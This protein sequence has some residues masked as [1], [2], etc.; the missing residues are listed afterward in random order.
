MSACR[1]PK[2]KPAA[3][4]EQGMVQCLMRA[5]RSGDPAAG[6]SSTPLGL[7]PLQ[8]LVGVGGRVEPATKRPHPPPLPHAMQTDVLESFWL[9]M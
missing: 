6:L 1:P 9:S 5:L 4:K 2:S 3:T 8:D 7:S